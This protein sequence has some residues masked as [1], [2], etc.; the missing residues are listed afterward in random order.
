M[1]YATPTQ[2]IAWTLHDTNILPGNTIGFSCVVSTAG[3]LCTQMHCDA[4]SVLTDLGVGTHWL[5]G[6]YKYIKS[7]GTTAVL[8]NTKVV[9]YIANP[10]QA[11][12]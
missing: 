1:D 6:N 5:P 7:T 4:V 12:Y 3:V 8:T 9:V 10:A 11:N 2:H